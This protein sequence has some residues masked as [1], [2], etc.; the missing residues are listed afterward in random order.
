MGV[1]IKTVIFAFG[2]DLEFTASQ[3]EKFCE[4]KLDV[5][6]SMDKLWHVWKYMRTME[7]TRHSKT[8]LSLS[9]LGLT[10]VDELQEKWMSFAIMLLA[11]LV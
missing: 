5:D 10:V 2:V 9:S 4:A 1:S 11:Y 6:K 7:P 3:L 8:C